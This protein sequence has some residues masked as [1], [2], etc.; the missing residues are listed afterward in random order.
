[1]KLSRKHTEKLFNMA[2]ILGVMAFFEPI[3]SEDEQTAEMMLKMQKDAIQTWL[4]KHIK[5]D[6]PL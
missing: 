2:T 1:M 3:T 6:Q 5:S 4:L